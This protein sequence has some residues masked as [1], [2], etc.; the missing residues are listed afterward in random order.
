MSTLI[1]TRLSDDLSIWLNEFTAKNSFTKRN[2]FESLLLNLREKLKKE[3]IKKSFIKAWKDKD[4][5]L[6]SEEWIF[7]YINQLK[8]M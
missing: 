5:L 1:S 6:L 2:V 4:L 8:Q 3:E 7:D